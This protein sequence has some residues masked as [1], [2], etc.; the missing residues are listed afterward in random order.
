MNLFDY[1]T[2]YL[3]ER[4]GTKVYRSELMHLGQ[5]YG[6]APTTIDS[7]RSYLTSAGYLTITNRGEYYVLR[8]IPPGYYIEH[9]KWEA[10]R[11][12]RQRQLK[13]DEFLWGVQR[14]WAKKRESKK[15]V[16]I[17]EREFSV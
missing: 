9:V 13:D 11:K 17:H 4:V 5:G 10:S 7:Y 2:I 8:E 12:Q 3:N 6:Y 16:F 1:M 15:K 14:L